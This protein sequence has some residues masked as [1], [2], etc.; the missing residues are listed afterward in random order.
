MDGPFCF[1][2]RTPNGWCKQHQHRLERNVCVRQ[3]ASGNAT[4]YFSFRCDGFS[5]EIFFFAGRWLGLGTQKTNFLLLKPADGP[6]GV[7][8]IRINK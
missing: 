1:H 6:M 2:R 8:H 5:I 3:V 7:T 4:Q